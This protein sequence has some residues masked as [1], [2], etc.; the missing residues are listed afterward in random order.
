[1][2]EFTVGEPVTMLNLTTRETLPFTPRI[3]REYRGCYIVYGNTGQHGIRIY[4][5]V[6]I[7][8]GRTHSMFVW[9]GPLADANAVIA[10][11]SRVK[12][13]PWA[14][15]ERSELSV[16]AGGMTAVPETVRAWP[17]LNSGNVTILGGAPKSE[18]GLIQ[19]GEKLADAWL[20]SLTHQGRL[21]PG[22]SWTLNGSM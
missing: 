16:V 18:L 19:K 8:P 11:S 7:V 4:S 22:F 14:L 17:V 20:Y 6:K 21:P 10:F 3:I 1:M 9:A 2:L 15:V 5:G 12:G 13:L